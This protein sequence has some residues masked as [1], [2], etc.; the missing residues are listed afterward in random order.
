MNNS[1][2][3]WL[4]ATRPPTLVAALVPV[5]LG[6]VLAW[7]LSGEVNIWLAAVTFLS[8]VCIQIATNFFNDALDAETGADSEARTG[9]Q[10][11]TQAGLLPGWFVKASG[12]GFL[13]AAAI[14]SLPLIWQAGWPIIAIGLVSMILAYGYTGAPLRLA[15]RGLGELFVILFFGVVAVMGSVYVQ[16]LEWRTEALLLGLQVG[17]LSAVLIAINNLRDIEVDRAAG[18]NT[19]ISLIGEKWGQWIVLGLSLDGL[20]SGIFWLVF[21]WPAAFLFPLFIFPITLIIANRVFC[22]RSG[23]SLNA[24][25]GVGALQ[26]LAF[27]LAFSL[28]PRP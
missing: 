9:P 7:R 20:L 10:R 8:A 27:A 21:G 15:Y 25:L 2:L 28:A 1:I 22:Q 23:P 26:M 24:L 3:A 12:V 19:L 4:K 16:L 18:K 14:L 17:C 11:A 5:W 6:T 13:V